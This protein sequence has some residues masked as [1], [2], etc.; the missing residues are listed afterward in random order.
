MEAAVPW[1]TRSNTFPCNAPARWNGA[2]IADFVS[3]P[4][5]GIKKAMI[6]CLVLSSFTERSKQEGHNKKDKE[7]TG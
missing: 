2:N 1:D 4:T 6:Y 7:N 3:G 5:R